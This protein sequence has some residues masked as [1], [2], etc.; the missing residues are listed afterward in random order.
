MFD[1]GA[2]GML[3]YP[4][5]PATQTSS[6]PE[7]ST[8]GATSIYPAA[9]WTLPAAAAAAGMSMYPLVPPPTSAY[10]AS[11]SLSVGAV[12][13]GR[14]RL[15]RRVRP[16]LRRHRCGLADGL[17]ED[18]AARLVLVEAVG[19]G[20]GD[21]GRCG[22]GRTGRARSPRQPERQHRQ[23][24]DPHHARTPRS[25]PPRVYFC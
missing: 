7:S 15:R 5:R 17:L 11:P 9:P 24:L 6:S 18:I 23:H 20:C 19:Q 22:G 14:H 12:D 4:A 21:G 25:Q 3:Q 2:T 16:G 8:Y 10:V 13:E 1:V